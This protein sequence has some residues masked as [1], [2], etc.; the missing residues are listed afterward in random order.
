VS[1]T[2]TVPIKVK[3]CNL[4]G[5]TINN[6]IAEMGQ[7]VE[8]TY[9]DPTFVNPSSTLIKCGAL[10][11]ELVGGDQTYFRVNLVD[12][13]IVLHSTSNTDLAGGLATTYSH[14]IRV[15]PTT[16]P[17]N[18]IETTFTLTITPICD[19]NGYSA[20]DLDRLILPKVV[21]TCTTQ[22]NQDCLDQA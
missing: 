1:T 13:L 12:K 8:A 21:T 15:W 3:P 10:V 2:F 7:K 14:T 6:L 16:Y 4:Q 18:V 9:L 11:W 17:L 19:L 20:P 5:L 22:P